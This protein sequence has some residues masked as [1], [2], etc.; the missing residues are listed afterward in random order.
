[1]A[2]LSPKQTF[3]FS[4]SLTGP[5]SARH[6]VTTAVA[7]SPWRQNLPNLG[8]ERMRRAVRVRQDDDGQAF[9]D[10]GLHHSVKSSDRA[11]VADDP[12]T[13]FRMMVEAERIG[14]GHETGGRWEGL[15]ARPGDGRLGFG[16]VAE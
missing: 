16:A 15:S 1:M 4:P 14:P 3:Q 2:A 7:K 10:I 13:I 11:V 5:C 12:P 6:S 8:S 9:I